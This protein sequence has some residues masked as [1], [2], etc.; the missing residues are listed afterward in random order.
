M[1]NNCN[2]CIII[3]ILPEVHVIPKDLKELWRI[4]HLGWFKIVKFV[5]LYCSNIS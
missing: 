1:N 4:V 2:I 5:K 3:I